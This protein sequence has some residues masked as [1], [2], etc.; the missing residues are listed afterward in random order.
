LC[1]EFKIISFSLFSG[2]H[3]GVYI[4]E[5]NP[6]EGTDN[7]LVK[8]LEVGQEEIKAINGKSLE[9]KSYL[10]IVEI[11]R[12]TRNSYTLNLLVADIWEE[13]NPFGQVSCGNRSCCTLF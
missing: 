10:E 9:G 2:Y 6:Y 4:S 5:I 7:D 3:F 8:P 12:D 11:I 1:F 13:S